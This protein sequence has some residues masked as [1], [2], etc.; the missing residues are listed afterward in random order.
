[1]GLADVTDLGTFAGEAIFTVCQADLTAWEISLC[2]AYLAG[3]RKMEI[4][5]IMQK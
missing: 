4:W 1:M 2:P 3:L 5:R